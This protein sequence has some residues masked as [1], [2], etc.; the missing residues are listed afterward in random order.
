MPHN[1]PSASRKDGLLL[2]AVQT[3]YEHCYTDAMNEFS[4]QPKTLDAKAFE[5]SLKKCRPGLLRYA[6]TLTEN[7][8]QAEDLVQETMRKMWEHRGGLRANSNVNAWA[9][10][11]LKNTFYDSLTK[12]QRQG[13]INGEKAESEMEVIA[14]ADRDQGTALDQRRVIQK[15]L[16]TMAKLPPEQREVMRLTALGHGGKEV[17]ADMDATP[18]I[19]KVRRFRGR[20]K[21]KAK[22]DPDDRDIIQSATT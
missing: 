7:R 22:L 2:Y 8:E 15:V 18:A 3:K 20:E 19:T 17:A 11:V 6:K 5:E 9:T 16:K 12:R 4:E 1:R 21:I 13:E 10:T 14:N